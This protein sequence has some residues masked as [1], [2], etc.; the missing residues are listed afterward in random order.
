MNLVLLAS[1]PELHSPLV[2]AS[3]YN[4]LVNLSRCLSD[5]NDRGRERV[6][7]EGGGGRGGG[8]GGGGGKEIE[9]K[10]E[11]S[12]FDVAIKYTDDPP[13]LSECMY[14][15]VCEWYSGT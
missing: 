6:G 7:R 9:T 12:C 15:T 13:S 11:L 5:D 8:G 1:P 2:R 10:C 14:D 3:F 4:P